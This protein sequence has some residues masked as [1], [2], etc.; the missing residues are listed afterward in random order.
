M[1]TAGIPTGIA[2]R[3]LTD[4]AVLGI[5]EFEIA[6]RTG[7]TYQG[8]LQPDEEI[9]T[10]AKDFGTDTDRALSAASDWLAGRGCPK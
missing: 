3:T 4:G 9:L 7:R 8:P 2:P 5:T 10:R 1:P 6:D